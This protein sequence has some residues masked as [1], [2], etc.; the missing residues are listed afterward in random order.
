M[1][2]VPLPQPVIDYRARIF[3]EATRLKLGKGEKE[4]LK[5]LRAQQVPVDWRARLKLERDMHT[6]ASAIMERLVIRALNEQLR[7]FT[8]GTP[9]AMQSK[10][11]E[12]FRKE[13]DKVIR[14]YA[15]RGYK[16]GMSDV[17]RYVD[18]VIKRKL[19][20]EAIDWDLYPSPADEIISHRIASFSDK[21]S[22]MIGQTVSKTALDVVNQG[23][24]QG[25]SVREIQEL[26]KQKAEVALGRSEVIVRTVVVK[27][28]N[29]GRTDQ[30]KELGIK[31]MELVG[32]DPNCDECQAVIANNP[33]NVD[34]VEEIEMS[35]HPN[36]T[37][38]WVPVIPQESLPSPAEPP[39]P[40]GRPAGATFPPEL[41]RE[42]K[43]TGA[44]FTKKYLKAKLEDLDVH[45]LEYERVKLF[46]KA[47][48]QLGKADYKKELADFVAKENPT[49]NDVSRLIAKLR[50]KIAPG[51]DID[52]FARGLAESFDTIRDHATWDALKPFRAKGLTEVSHIRIE[53]SD[54]V[55]PRL[56]KMP[57]SDPSFADMLLMHWLEKKKAGK[58]RVV[59]G[60]V[61]KKGSPAKRHFEESIRQKI[62]SYICR[63]DES[64]LPMI[65]K[66]IDA[67]LTASVATTRTIN[68]MIF[69]NK[70]IKVY[71]GI[72]FRRQVADK[73]GVLKWRKG[74]KITLHENPYSFWTMSRQI[75]E[76]YAAPELLEPGST[77]I[78]VERTIRPGDILYNFLQRAFLSQCEV[79]VRN[80]GDGEQVKV[81][82]RH[83]KPK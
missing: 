30:A 53:L 1:G 50:N 39:P 79:V 80:N 36:H 60:E 33:Y 82:A 8:K 75:A 42:L 56:V 29:L 48:N 41:D 32:C 40:V 11:A 19:V 14:E 83:I 63:G 4:T 52:E 62:I 31:Q 38:S 61:A 35:L 45:P 64:K 26:L 54:L 70:P 46:R 37:G 16:L 13:I 51:T 55:G 21:M 27:A 59:L 20:G 76:E 5:R 28:S 22:K 24:R 15:E 65:E 18:S 43:K 12:R 7:A 49:R 2:L 58:V 78:V 57:S 34:E 69:G 10:A 23:V 25:L 6:K 74:T 73:L 66:A 3:A 44:L 47:V 77:S 72:R 17:V 9:S 81:I 71:R 67:A 68:R